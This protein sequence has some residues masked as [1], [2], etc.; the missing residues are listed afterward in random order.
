MDQTSKKH[1]NALPWKHIIQSTGSAYIEIGVFRTEFNGNIT[2]MKV[3]LLKK[4]IQSAWFPI[5]SWAGVYGG[6][7]HTTSRV[8]RCTTNKIICGRKAIGNKNEYFLKQYKDHST[9]HNK[10]ILYKIA[11]MYLLILTF[12][13]VEMLQVAQNN[14]SCNICH[15]VI[16]CHGLLTC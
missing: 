11:H 2:W 6:A 12:I 3:S 4:R 7:M 8:S 9:F 16:S 13:S 5:P 14:K 1:W 10:T 15:D